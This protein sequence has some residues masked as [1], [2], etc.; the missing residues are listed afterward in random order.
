VLTTVPFSVQRTKVW[1]VTGVAVTVCVLPCTNVPPPLSVPS[2]AGEALTLIVYSFGVRFSVA[3]RVVFPWPLV[4]LSPVG[5][6]RPWPR[7]AACYVSP[8]AGARTQKSPDRTV[9]RGKFRHRN[10]RQSA[11]AERPVYQIPAS[12]WRNYRCPQLPQRDGRQTLVDFRVLG[13]P[14]FCWR[15]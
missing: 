15:M 9:N 11:D 4:V 14:D 12:L 3:S 5:P 2:A 13:A 10:G 6:N 8:R 1:P 7:P